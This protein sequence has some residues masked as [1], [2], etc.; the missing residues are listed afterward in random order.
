MMA[1]AAMPPPGPAPR[2]HLALP[3]TR[4]RV[5]LDAPLARFTW[6]RV[7]GPADVLFR[8]ADIADLADFLKALPTTVQVWPLGVGSNVIVRDGGVAGVVV[9]L[10]GPFV[11][12]SVEGDTVVAGAGALAGNVARLAAD[13]GLGGLEF[14]SG[15]PGSIGGAVRMNAGAFG[16]ET[17]TALV[18]AE[19]VSRAGEI[20]RVTGEEIGLA[21]RH[22]DLAAD[23]IVM[24]ACF[25]GTPDNATVVRARL[26][27][28]QAQREASQPLRTR[29]GGSTFR[30]PLG[31][32]A[33]ELIDAAGCRGLRIGAAHVSEKHCNFLIA[34]DGCTATDIETLGE[35]VRRRVKEK[36]GVD[37]QWEI[38]RIGREAGQ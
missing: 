11:E 32:K 5:T 4:G 31:A 21:Y 20:R 36:T 15:V 18:W 37:L 9:L 29:T 23:D 14:L 3:P 10:R 22:S 28:V 6:F 12:I 2:M 19:I 35:T 30:N 24:R 33:W 1:A 7:G 13:A 17:K 34:E 27:D 26:L 8:P 25:K 38:K 16:G